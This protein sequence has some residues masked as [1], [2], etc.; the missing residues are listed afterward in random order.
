MIVE[1]LN[2]TILFY[3]YSQTALSLFQNLSIGIPSV[4]TMKRGFQYF[5]GTSVRGE[6]FCCS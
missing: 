3:L 5:G 6:I 4:E 2:V 1:Y